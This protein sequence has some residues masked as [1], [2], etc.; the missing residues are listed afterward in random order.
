MLATPPKPPKA[1][2]A[3]TEIKMEPASPVGS[4]V[5]KQAMSTYADK[6][7]EM[8]VYLCAL[9]L[10]VL[11][12]GLNMDVSIVVDKLTGPLAPAALA[13]YI[14]DL[15]PD[16][17]FQL[18]Q[19]PDKVGTFILTSADF[20]PSDGVKVSNH[21]M[22]AVSLANMGEER[23]KA[24]I[25]LGMCDAE[26]E[27]AEAKAKCASVQAEFAEALRMGANQDNALAK[28]E[29]ATDALENAE[30]WLAFRKR[31]ADISLC[32]VEVPADGNC[33]LWSLRCFLEEAYD[34]SEKLDPKV[35]ADLFGVKVLRADLAS[36][37]RILKKCS[38]WQ[39]HF[40]ILIA[41]DE[42][43]ATPK[44]R[45]Q[46]KAMTSP[47]T[48]AQKVLLKKQKQQSRV[49]VVKGHSKAPD[50]KPTMSKLPGLRQPT[51]KKTQMNSEPH[52]EEEE[53]A[54][55]VPDAEEQNDMSMVVVKKHVRTCKKKKK[56]NKERRL[57]G[58]RL[59]IAEIG[60]SYAKWQSSHWQQTG[61]KKAGHCKSG[62]WTDLLKAIESNTMPK[63]PCPA[64]QILLDSAGFC[65][66]TAEKWMSNQQHEEEPDQRVDDADGAS[67]PDEAEDVPATRPDEAEG[68]GG[69]QEK[70][71]L[72]VE[73]I[74]RA[75]D[76]YCE[77]GCCK[78]ELDGIG[79]NW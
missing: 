56:T 11:A 75:V 26:L 35:E 37:W 43:P 53:E 20:K 52:Q 27:V 21:W 15:V 4:S 5:L 69:E 19:N 54:P 57:R 63:E 8:G 34:G 48:P 1:K 16:S 42:D 39:K 36:A 6:V 65:Q 76:V 40:K 50:W 68:E 47:A 38:V 74:L 23:L 12:T 28:V 7:S 79:M 66:E 45:V 78:V 61:C 60:M 51:E 24:L 64:C 70:E 67:R 10:C 17:G 31:C 32:P 71:D 30:A 29:S 3:K 73:A 49:E 33:M 44:K 13:D 46:P 58:L 25:S 62:L 55:E 18:S 9:D 22:P 41:D 77:A 72:S 2:K 14:H 59:Y